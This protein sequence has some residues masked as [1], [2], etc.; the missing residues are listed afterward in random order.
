MNSKIKASIIAGIILILLVGAVVALT[1]TSKPAS[2]DSSSSTIV[3]SKLLY[4][5]KPEDIASIVIANANG[6]IEL[7]KAGDSYAVAGLENLPIKVDSVTALLDSAAKVTTKKTIEEGAS[8][9]AKYGLA[10]PTATVKVTFSDSAATVKEFMIGD[11]STTAGQSYFALKGENTVYAVDT[12]AYSSLLASKLALID[13]VLVAMPAADEAGAVAYPVIDDVSVT[14][15]DLDYTTTL[16]HDK[17]LGDPLVA[18]EAE[19]DTTH[20]MTS[21]IKAELKFEKATPFVRGMFGLSGAAVTAHPTKEELAAAKI[22]EGSS[23]VVNFTI[24]GKEHNLIIGAPVAA[25]GE[26]AEG[27]LCYYDGLDVLLRIDK[28]ALPWMTTDAINLVSSLIYL[29]NIFEV[30]KVDLVTKSGTTSFD[31]KGRD[32]A[33]TVTMNGKTMTPDYF[34]KFY[35]Y[36]LSVP[37]DELYLEEPTAE[38]SDVK[39][40][41]TLRNGEV[42]TLEYFNVENR[43]TIIVFDGVPSYLSRTSYFERLLS[44]MELLSTE[45][46]IVDTY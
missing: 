10:S 26:F 36:L 15:G 23:G 13:T 44:N 14:R 35:Q 31:L 7:Q 8:D 21:P 39:L 1:L 12:A 11:S 32:D 27:Y 28:T 37:P 34:K 41:Y 4:E 29:P 22:S 6:G 40:T 30:A 2:D 33:F 3:E 38:T 17:Y 24:E 25:E 19:S 20:I 46:E 45:G 43:R 42:H 5:K 9:L 18:P 16:T